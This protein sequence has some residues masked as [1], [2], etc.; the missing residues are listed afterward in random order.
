MILSSWKFYLLF[1][2]NQNLGTWKISQLI[3]ERNSKNVKKKKKKKTVSPR[4]SEDLTRN[5][6][7]KHQLQSLTE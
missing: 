3:Q 2:I 6:L 1:S 7:L 4:Q 5:F